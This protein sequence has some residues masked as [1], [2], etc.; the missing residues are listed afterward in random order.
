LQDDRLSPP[1]F[2]RDV[3]VSDQPAGHHSH[4]DIGLDGERDDDVD[5]HMED[6][7]AG[8]DEAIR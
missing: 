5:D 1:E 4:V 2:Y 8:D 7:G 3:F 6:L